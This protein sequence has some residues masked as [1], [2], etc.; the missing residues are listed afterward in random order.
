MARTP[1]QSFES[2]EYKVEFVVDKTSELK[3]IE[4]IGNGRYPRLKG[5][6]LEGDYYRE[7]VRHKADTEG[8]VTIETVSDRYNQGEG[9]Q[10]DVYA[11]SR[12]SIPENAGSYLAYHAGF[13]VLCGGVQSGDQV[14]EEGAPLFLDVEDEGQFC[15]GRVVGSAKEFSRSEK[16]EEFE[17]LRSLQVPSVRNIRTVD[18]DLGLE[19]AGVETN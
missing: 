17:K 4:Y 3:T 11:V 2:D 12:L 19:C 6:R 15:L 8:V 16:I 9:L 5:S 13:P 10:A 18:F 7:Y 14:S 1:E